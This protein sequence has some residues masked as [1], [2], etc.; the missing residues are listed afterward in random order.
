MAD[1]ST[2]NGQDKPY[3]L[4]HNLYSICSIMVRYTLAVKGAPQKPA[5][6]MVVKEQEVDIFHGA[7]LD[8]QFLLEINPRG[9]VRSLCK[10]PLQYPPENISSAGS[11]GYHR[12][13]FKSGASLS[14]RS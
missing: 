8:E 13:Q 1:E 10:S 4:Y 2:S 9:Q 5:A 14:K 11:T 7:Q 12:S 3:V 6:A